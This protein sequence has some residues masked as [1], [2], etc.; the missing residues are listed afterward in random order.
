[1][2]NIKTVHPNVHSTNPP[3][4]VVPAKTAAP[5]PSTAVATK[6]RNQDYLARYLESAA[7]TTQGRIIGMGK[8]GNIIF[9]DDQTE[10][11]DHVYVVLHTDTLHGLIKF[12]Q[13]GSP[14]ERHMG[15]ISEGYIPPSRESLGDTDEAAWPEGLNGKPEDPWKY[16]ICVVLQDSETDELLTFATVSPTGRN[17]V[18]R[19]L[20]HCQRVAKLHPG[21]LTLVRLRVG[22]YVSKRGIKVAVPNFVGC[23]HTS[24]DNASKSGNGEDDLN[25]EIGF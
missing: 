5:S 23:G 10:V 11:P 19:L 9:R 16:Q 2:T 25:D 4:P 6:D 24:A 1:M 22:S 14:P 13:D 12:S 20:H 17:A 7:I 8:G 15:L 18:N 3:R 21:S